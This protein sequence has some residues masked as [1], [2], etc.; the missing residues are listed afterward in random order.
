[1]VFESKTV[2]DVKSR[3]TYNMLKASIKMPMQLNAF[4]FRFPR[5]LLLERY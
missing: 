3:L 5:R 2:D 1:M 4:I